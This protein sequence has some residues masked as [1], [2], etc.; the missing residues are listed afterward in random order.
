MLFELVEYL[1]N[2]GPNPEAGIMLLNGV[3]MITLVH[4]TRYVDVW[5]DAKDYGAFRDGLPA[6][7]YRVQIH[8]PGKAISD[9]VRA[10][11]IVEAATTI[12]C[13]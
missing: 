5:V 4:P 2:R 6:M 13:A 9:D 12:L 11:T 7:Y 10:Q 3:L 8:T 1:Q